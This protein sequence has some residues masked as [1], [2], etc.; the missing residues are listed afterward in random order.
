MKNNNENSILYLLIILLLIVVF[1]YHCNYNKKVKK[2]T[3]I[4][5]GFKTK[6]SEK[7]LA[8]QQLI[9]FPKGNPLLPRSEQNITIVSY[10]GDFNKKKTSKSQ[11]EKL[12]L[13][14]ASNGLILLPKGYIKVDLDN[15]EKIGSLVIKGLKNGRVDI[16]NGKDNEFKHIFNINTEFCDDLLQYNKL[17]I[18]QINRVSPSSDLKMKSLKIT[19][20]SN[21][22]SEPIKLEL[23]EA[24]NGTMKTNKNDLKITNKKIVNQNDE[25]IKKLVVNSDNNFKSF[26][27]IIL[28]KPMLLNGFSLKTNIKHFKVIFG[29]KGFSN[30]QMFHGGVNGIKKTNYYFDDPVK[31]KTLKIIPF[32]DPKKINDI[33][34]FMSDIN[35]YNFSSIVK[36]GFTNEDDKEDITQEVNASLDI[37]NACQ[38]LAYQEDI[39]QETYKLQ[40]FKKYNLKLQKQEQ[41]LE[42]LNRT[43]E[44]LKDNRRVQMEKEDTLSVVKNQE[45]RGEEVKLLEKLKENKNKTIDF[46]VNLA[47]I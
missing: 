11:K 9:T 46:K 25:E 37:Q 29:N 26:V 39:N 12:Y 2:T 36:E 7:H 30:G 14:N 44:H 16:D 42:E 35:L 45:L 38:A 21:V 40:Q 6:Y 28:P 17:N 18:N 4:E 8:G 34:Y 22:A 15:Y 43:I 33:V 10:Q 41:E 19:N 20:T 24:Y 13:D 5:E 47:N 1:V 23:M 32:I 3:M 27:K 31:T